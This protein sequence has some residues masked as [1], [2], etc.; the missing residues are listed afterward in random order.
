[1]EHQ[2]ETALTA[3]D[4]SAAFHTVDN[5]ILLQVL[6]AQ[7]GVNDHVLNWF[8]TYLAPRKFVVDVEGHK[9]KEKD[10]QFSVPQV[11]FYIWVMC[12]QYSMP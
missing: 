8:K 6:K 5:Q 11:L 10:L 7:F 12:L 1:M 3:L 2:K 9:S 4:L